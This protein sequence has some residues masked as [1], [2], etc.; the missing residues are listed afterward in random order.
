MNQPGI[1][2]EVLDCLRVLEAKP[3]DTRELLI[4][5]D[6]PAWLWMMKY[7]ASIRDKTA[8]VGYQM[9]DKV[10][11][12]SKADGRLELGLAVGRHRLNWRKHVFEVSVEVNDGSEFARV[13][14]KDAATCAAFE[15]FLRHARARSGRK[16]G[17]DSDKVRVKVIRGTTWKEVTSYPKRPPDSVV[18]GDTTVTDLLADMRQFINSEDEY[19]KYGRPFKRNVLIIGDPGAGKSSLITVLASELDLDICFVS[20]NG[21][22]DEKNLG[23]AIGN[24]TSN[25]MLVIEDVDVLCTSA[26]GSSQAQN[27]LSVLT[28]VLDG[29][30]HKHKLI[31]VLTSANPEALEGVLVRHG[32]VDYTC[33]LPPLGRK[34]VTAMVKRVFPEQHEKLTARVW[35]EIDRLGGTT[36]TVLAQFLFKH[37]H[38]SPDDL[39]TKELTEGTHTK[40]I[41]DGKR[42]TPQNFYM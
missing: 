20:V 41:K 16:G 6:N 10:I 2:E 23:A 40:H 3:L 7:G 15:D 17:C 42:E 24:L 18:T 22:M 39:E 29:A 36:A 1:D 33:R 34:Q 32:R 21:G 26:I 8:G 28:N 25:S 19:V 4:E 27:S 5:A 37:R 38:D 30:L 12:L 11:T 31:T 35:E 14:L 9:A 13:H